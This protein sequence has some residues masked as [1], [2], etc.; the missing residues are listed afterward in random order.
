MSYGLIRCNFIL[1]VGRVNACG[2]HWQRGVF[3]L[4]EHEHR[5]GSPTV[6]NSTSTHPVPG[7]SYARLCMPDETHRLRVSAVNTIGIA[8]C[9]R[10]N[11]KWCRAGPGAGHRQPLHRRHHRQ[12]WPVTWHRLTHTR[13]DSRACTPDTM[14]YR[15]PGTG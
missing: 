3:M 13:H 12:T 15:H 4:A 1:S 9:H 14:S 7:L 2:G 5:T 6:R 10:T 11:W 8:T